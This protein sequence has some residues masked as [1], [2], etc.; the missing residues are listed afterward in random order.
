MD[1]DFYPLVLDSA[2]ATTASHGNGSIYEDLAPHLRQ[3]LA[4][5]EATTDLPIA[6]FV[7]ELYLAYPDALFVLT[8][9]EPRAWWRS[10]SRQMA[11]AFPFEHSIGRNRAVAYGHTQSH[12][13]LYSRRYVGHNVEVM[14]TIPCERLL[15]LDI[16]ERADTD[17]WAKLSSF[18][19]VTPPSPHRP[20]PS[21]KPVPTPADAPETL[22]PTP[23]RRKQRGK[24]SRSRK[25]EERTAASES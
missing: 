20:F 3:L 8:T 10:A 17:G 24:K 12:A 2:A 13:P 5:T 4:G 21:A 1:L 16:V 9:R 18:L 11:E 6:L 25:I 14:R 7:P 22:Q 19:G 23:G 15:L